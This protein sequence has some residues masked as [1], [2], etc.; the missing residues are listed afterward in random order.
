MKLY[1]NYPLAAKSF[2]EDHGLAEALT[3]FVV[4]RGIDVIIE[5]G[6]YLG[7]GSTR[8]IASCFARLRAPKAFV[9]IEV[10]WEHFRNAKANLR[11]YS[12]IDCRWGASVERAAA[13]RF[14]SNDEAIKNHQAYDYVWIDDVE[15]PVA[16]YTAEIMGR[17]PLRGHKAIRALLRDLADRRE[18]SRWA[19]FWDGEDLLRRFCKIHR[20]HQPLIV[21][22]SA[23]G[24]GYLEFQIMRDV[25]GQ[26]EYMLLLDDVH[27]LKHFRSLRDVR[28]DSSFNILALDM[29]YGWLLAEH[30]PKRRRIP[31]NDV[32][33]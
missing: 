17:S 31:V 6:T 29:N 11:S 16:Y 15:D 21:L 26:A 23:G 28:A 12:F 18:Q 2:G 7:L 20:N 30:L 14:I 13:V 4:T 5:T 33:S 9:T 10:S 22:D 27:H 3:E 25:M 24:I 32:C 8:A 1:A 19:I